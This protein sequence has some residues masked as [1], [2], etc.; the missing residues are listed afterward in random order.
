MNEPI[1]ISMPDMIRRQRAAKALSL[2]AA[3]KTAYLYRGDEFHY[4]FVGEGRET[5]VRDG[6]VCFLTAAEK[7]A[8]E[9]VKGRL[10]ISSEQKKDEPET[11]APLPVDDREAAN[12]AI[13]EDDYQAARKVAERLGL[14]LADKTKPTVYQA[15]AEWLSTQTVER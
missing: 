1:V 12:Q 9:K 3:P 13:G 4:T 7:K 14:E 2:A 6:R 10:L 5:L 15:L 8:W 11:F